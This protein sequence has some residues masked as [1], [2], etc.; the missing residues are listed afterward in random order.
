MATASPPS[1]TASEAIA[2][3]QESRI[4][5]QLGQNTSVE[6]A[7]DSI[8]RL[9]DPKRGRGVC[10]SECFLRRYLDHLRDVESPI[11]R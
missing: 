8:A 9:Q 11:R 4:I 6:A 10:G 1:F 3:G 5:I 7:A 2:Q